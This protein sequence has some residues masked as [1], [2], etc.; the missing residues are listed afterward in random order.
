MPITDTQGQHARKVSC[1]KG[2]KILKAISP[3]VT[4]QTASHTPQKHFLSKKWI[5]QMNN[6]ASILVKGNNGGW[7]NSE[8][9]NRLI[10]EF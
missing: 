8:T 10:W 4:N 2:E 3:H 5:E 7:E 6:L 9:F 1:V